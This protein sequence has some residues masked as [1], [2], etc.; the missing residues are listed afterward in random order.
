MEAESPIVEARRFGAGGSERADAAALISWVPDAR[1]AALFAGD[2]SVWPLTP[3]RIAARLGT[4][5]ESAGSESGDVAGGSG[6]IEGWTALVDGRPAG[7]AQIAFA[8]A[9][10]ARIAW[11]IVDPARRGAGVVAVLL[12]AMLRDAERRGVDTA[13]L[14]VVPGNTPA[15]RAYARLGFAERGA[16]P[17]HP[18]YVLMVRETGVP[19]L[20][21]DAGVPC[22]AGLPDRSR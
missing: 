15:L 16:C 14:H 18:E 13:Y 5:G 3:E 6:A 11:V 8:T 17:E 10:T 20:A 2:A 19:G 9:R 22:L 4:R 21:T 7:H 1:A 12:G